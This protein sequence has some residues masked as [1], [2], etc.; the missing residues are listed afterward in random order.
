[1]HYQWVG[2]LIELCLQIKIMMNIYTNLMATS[3]DM[4]AANIYILI[5][6]AVQ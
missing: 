1:M 5:N 6:A 2:W 3:I 4:A